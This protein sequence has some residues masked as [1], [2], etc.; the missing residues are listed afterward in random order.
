ME[1]VVGV[2]EEVKEE[3]ELVEERTW[4]EEVDE[5]WREVEEHSRMQKEEVGV[6]EESD[7]LLLFQNFR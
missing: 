4:M 6:G 1:V 3:P 5:C 2:G 7:T